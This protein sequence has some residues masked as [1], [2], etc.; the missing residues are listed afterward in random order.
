MSCFG[1]L[2]IVSIE[3]PSHVVQNPML[4]YPSPAQILNPTVQLPTPSY[5]TIPR[6]PGPAFIPLTPYGLL[7]LQLERE[8][9]RVQKINYRILLDVNTLSQQ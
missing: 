6:Q 7:H 3:M 8:F 5:C 2:H 4:F 1:T 9:G